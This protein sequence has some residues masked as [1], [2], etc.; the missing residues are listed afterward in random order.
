MELKRV[1]INDK[2]LKDNGTKQMNFQDLKIGDYFVYVHED[3]DGEYV[4]A[5][6][7]KG[8][9]ALALTKIENCSDDEHKG[10]T[11]IKYE[12]STLS[13]FRDIQLLGADKVCSWLDASLPLYDMED[14]KVLRLGSW[15]NDPLIKNAR[16]GKIKGWINDRGNKQTLD[17]EYQ[18][19]RGGV[20]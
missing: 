6:M 11:G 3:S 20:S 19:G 1:S 8:F 14:K 9:P 7:K 18:I 12:T 13:R 2:I 15:R 5:D 16:S 4:E 17:Q 10:K